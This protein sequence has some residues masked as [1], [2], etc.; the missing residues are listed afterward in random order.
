MSAHYWR[1]AGQAEKN[2]F[3]S[4]KNGYHGETV[5]A[6]SVTDIPLFKRTYEPLLR[7]SVQVPTPDARLAEPGESAEAFA[8]RCADALEA[9][10]AEHA[11]TTAAFIIEPLVQGAAGMAMYHPVYLTPGARTVRPIRRAPD[12]RRN[13]RGIW[14]HRDDVRV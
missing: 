10:L 3:I 8:L 13:R 4:L 2:E 7:H 6:L 1:N 14:P 9:H 12:R 11:A 5:G